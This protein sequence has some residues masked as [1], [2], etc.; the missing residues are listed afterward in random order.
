MKPDT[1]PAVSIAED[2][3]PTIIID[4][5]EQDLLPISFDH[6]TDT[7]PTGDYSYRGGEH[8]FAIERKSLADLMGC[9]GHDRSRFEA[10]LKRMRAYD[11]ARLLIVGSI[12]DFRSGHYRSKILPATAEASLRAF[13]ARYIPI[14]WEATQEAAAR[15]VELWAYWHYRELVKAARRAGG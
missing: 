7:L 14:R 12:A 11:F 3:R 2:S 10:Q 1:L 15:R 4:T 9:I 5:R 8:T 13:E 6:V